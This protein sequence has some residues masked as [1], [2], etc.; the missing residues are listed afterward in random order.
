MRTTL[1]LD[2]DLG[3]KLEDRMRRT[4]RSFKETVNE[5]IRMGLAAGAVKPRRRFTVKARRMGLRSGVD[6]AS[7]HDLD[8]ELE[9]ERF[10][11]VTR[12]LGGK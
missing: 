2:G 5:V 8:T 6:P 7:A 12:R 9:V 10:L 4:G 1:T 11:E 3:R